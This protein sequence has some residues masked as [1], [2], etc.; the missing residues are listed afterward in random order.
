MDRY[1]EF[2][3]TRL[4]I[5]D[6]F[7][8]TPDLAYEKF[9]VD[10]CS[11]D[12]IMKYQAV[13]SFPS[14]WIQGDSIYECPSFKIIDRDHAEY[15][16][17]YDQGVCYALGFLEE[18]EGWVY[19]LQG[20]SL[21]QRIQSSV[22]H[23]NYMMFEKVMIQ[24]QCVILHASMIRYKNKMILFTGPS[25]VG[26]ST[27][28]ELWNRYTGSRIINGDRVLLRKKNGL[29]H[30]FGLPMNGSSAICE[31]DAGEIQAIIVLE[32]GKKGNQSVR[33]S[34]GET[35]SRLYGEM[36]VNRWNEVFVRQVL[37]M[38]VSIALEVPVYL[39]R[40]SKSEEAVS[41]LEK[42][43]REK[44]PDDNKR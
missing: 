42:I 38:T 10:P 31:N 33:L 36:T 19:Y 5:Q 29:W 43:L 3:E 17:F 39:Y 4:K 28:A 30:G 7:T 13:T 15:R 12:Y 14:E 2:A 25:G 26:K 32:K 11:V 34:P 40:C 24:F 35:L 8:Y 20:G 6:Y 37:D 1:Y 41:V 44:R 9:A 22:A 27:Q 18:S 16:L 23:F 21:E